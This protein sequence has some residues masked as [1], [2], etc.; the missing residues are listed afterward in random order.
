[1]DVFKL[2]EHL[3]QDYA[4]YAQSFIHIQ[5]ERLHHY[6]D[7]NLQQGV[8]WPDPLIQLNP[9]FRP[10]AYVSEL[11]RDGVLHPE[12][13]HIFQKG[14]EQ[15][16]PKPL[17][18]HQHQLDAIKIAQSGQNYILTTGTG[19]G[20]SLAYI[21]PIVDYVLRQGATR[22]IQ[23][24]V[25]YPMNA[26]ANSQYGELEKFLKHGYPDGKGPVTFA[27][28]TGQ[29][30]DE[31]RREIIANPPNILLTNYVMLE[32]LMTRPKE[33]SLIEAARGLQFLVLD[34]LHTYRGRQGADV[35]LLV[36]RVRERLA[37]SKLQC[38]GTSA[39]LA[40]EGTYAEQ[41]I[42]IARVG[43][44]M[45]GAPVYPQNII[46]ETLQRA[47]PD[48]A[49]DNP[50]FVYELTQ[51][52][53]HQ[54]ELQPPTTYSEFV[55]HPLSRWIEST[56]G[57]TADPTGD[58]LVRSKPRSIAGPEGAA[59]DLSQMTG[60][61][62]EICAAIIEAWLLAGY[63]C[64]PNPD[65]SMAPFAF[66]LHQFISPGDTVYTTIE[67]EDQRYLTLSGQRYVAGDRDKVLFPLTFCRECG[68]EYYVVRLLEQKE[69]IR[70]EPRDFRDRLDEDGGEA[71]YLYL[72]TG[73]PWPDDFDQIIQRVPEDWTEDHNGDERI[74]SNRKKQLPQ[75]L[76]LSTDG[77]QHEN[78]QACVFVQSPFLFCL[79]CGVS[80]SARQGDFGKLASLS[81]EGRSSATTILSL[82]AIL[83]LKAS[84]LDRRAQKLLSF[85]DNRQDASLQAGHFNDFIEVG[86]LRGAIYRAALLAGSEG[87][88]HESIAHK[89]FDAL[90]LPIE[91]YASEPA[92]RFQ[93]RQD[94]DHALRQ[95]LGYRIYRDLR[96]GWR[97][98][99]PNLEQSGLL[100]ID[101]LSLDDLCAAED[102][103]E[104][105]HPALATASPATRAKV[106]KVFLDF[107]RRELAIKVDYLNPRFQES[108]K[109]LSS[110]K[111]IDPWAVDEN[112]TMEYAAIL[113]PRP[114]RPGDTQGNAFVSGRGGLGMYLRRAGA[115]TGYDRDTY[116]RIG[117]PETETIIR[118]MLE[119][120]RIAGLVERVDEPVDDVPGYQL[121]ASGIRWRAG[122]GRQSFLDPIRVPQA[123]DQGGRT[124]PFF[125][126]FYKEVAAS[127]QQLEAHEH[128]A[129]VPYDERI[130][131]EEKFR[132]GDLPVLYCSP[133]MELGVDI[134]ELNVVNMRNVPPTPANYAQRSGRAGRSGQPALVFTYCST[135]S[136][137]DQYFFKRPE[138]MV[139]GAV[140]PPRLDLTN[141]DLLR[142][143]VHAIWLAEAR[144][145][146]G[147]T[148]KD[149]LDLSGTAPT[150]DL[151]PDKQK[152]VDASNA[153]TLALNR[154]RRVLDMVGD[155]LSQVGWYRDDWLDKVLANISRAFD[156]TCDRWRNLYRAA[157]KQAKGQDAIIRDA[158]RSAADKR[159][160]I[161]LRTEAEG[162]L[163]LL[164]EIENF[165]QSDFYSYRY[166]AT[167][168]FL[169][170]YSFPRLPIS[171]FVPARRV[172]Q[173]DE[174]LSR[175][176]FLAVSEFGPRAIIYHEG[177]RYIINQVILPIDDQETL[178]A[179][180]KQ[181][182][183]CG[184]L[185]PLHGNDNYDLCQRCGKPLGEPL[186]ALIRMQNVVTKRRDRI[187]SDEEERL[188]MGYEI[189][190]GVRFPDSNGRPEYQSALVLQGDKVLAK[191][192]YAQAATLYRIN[193]GW[194]RRKNRQLHG[195]VLDM[196]RGYWARNEQMDETQDPADPMSGQIRRVIPYVEDTRNALLIEP[197][198]VLKNEEMAGLQAALKRAIQASYQLEENELAAEP[199]PDSD[200][201]RT[202]LF[203]EAAEGGAGVLRRLIEEPHAFA[204][205]AAE[206]L[207]ICHFDPESGIDLRR[208]PRSTED[209]EAACYDCLLS[210]NNQRE[211]AI[212]D[213]QKIRGTLL[214]LTNAVV[215]AS[216][217][218]ATREDH[219]ERLLSLAGSELEV[220][221]LRYLDTH[222]HRLPDDAQALFEGCKTR[223]DFVY[224]QAYTVVY[225]DGSQH[226]YAHRQERDRTQVACMEDEGYTVIRFGYRD[227]W[228]KI[229]AANPHIF[230][231]K[232]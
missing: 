140:T 76:L 87:L 174:F 7:D 88:R 193:M 223:P 96:R 5:D 66:R 21:V 209:C 130:K 80:Y 205:V 191:L 45:F 158:S 93:A 3:T 48:F 32:L 228:D 65:T 69:G 63:Q 139:A 39:T 71:G 183:N 59:R 4:S 231:E 113:Y 167:E 202:L 15:Q 1:M 67:P 127:L 133:T 120:L 114:T 22:G 17:L 124:N 36:R 13:E 94:T 200:N 110:Q 23:A 104:Q 29:E 50:A 78:G 30:S 203:Y 216:P 156:A 199:L 214:D 229:L 58:R 194:A 219:L 2:R 125:I 189:R 8:F 132:R 142:A 144:I 91:A 138:R 162:Q 42:E 51:S 131:R 101:Y 230:G 146:L 180:M 121:V 198:G 220:E 55:T 147:E 26:L 177:S 108:I 190:S 164:I 112:E 61:D 154:S 11:V 33:R 196:E 64:E 54:T 103:W 43:T 188:R 9:M 145:D 90:K 136:P 135:G 35:A 152:D 73:R 172:K 187:S 222:G 106:C 46:G 184:Y 116:G 122:S 178:T 173:R 25:V 16:R 218:S 38:V 119:A 211:H 155:E 163:R 160:A 57:V 27:S 153:R 111:L 40:T 85:T 19:S 82:S 195:F 41:R 79:N 210:Y 20:K 109:Q 201:R 12:C 118:Q 10:G 34:E 166:F 129:Q 92:A 53:D 171:A 186:Q 141:Q 107:M 217:T 212:L 213:R 89:V 181:C 24:I 62:L 18:F 75:H 81:S 232:A 70:V 150:L 148:L 86:L 227:D 99:S 179:Q 192:T 143:H 137:H 77:I 165:G 168:G 102:I 49:Y 84:D 44:Q 128:T 123:P 204:H 221:W 105:C 149:I 151:L 175:P 60:H 31:R 208:A 37:P 176:R 224:E 157:L 126:H 134:A 170:G 14:K 100:E 74:R 159:Q 117:V 28:Y 47:T 185:H 169:P 83:M 207:A 161:R 215:V 206:A 182:N 95:V 52:I 97:I 197:F 226:D 98:T 56:F 225:V 72:N 6:I 68:Q 115:F